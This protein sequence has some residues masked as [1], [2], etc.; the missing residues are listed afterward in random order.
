MAVN[1]IDPF[2]GQMPYPID[3]RMVAANVGVRD[4]IPTNSRWAGMHVWTQAERKLWVL[5]CTPSQVNSNANWK[6]VWPIVN[7]IDPISGVILTSPD[8]HR[9]RVTVDNS[10]NLTTT[11]I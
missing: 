4:A 3:L 1:T 7:E 5:D 2:N 6:Q 11:A 10:G 9:Y 8:G